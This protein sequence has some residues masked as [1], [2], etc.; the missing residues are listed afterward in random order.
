[1]RLFSLFKLEL[2][3]LKVFHY[4]Q[5]MNETINCLFFLVLEI[6]KQTQEIM[7]P[8]LNVIVALYSL[9]IQFHSEY[10]L[11]VCFYICT[12][13]WFSLLTKTD[14]PQTNTHIHFRLTIDVIFACITL[15]GVHWWLN[16][17]NEYQCSCKKCMGKFTDLVLMRLFI[18]ES[19]VIYCWLSPAF[20]IRLLLTVICRSYTYAFW[21]LKTDNPK[22]FCRSSYTFSKYKLQCR[23]K[24]DFG[25]S[26]SSLFS[27][28]RSRMEFVNYPKYVPMKNGQTDVCNE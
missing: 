28:L 20:I 15:C 7:T 17:L 3:Q 1:M 24:P 16:M 9:S 22:A 11:S 27:L 23:L 14:A 5:C 10:I 6:N 13:N 4:S 8:I 19:T 2:S 12:S 26:N 21:A 18:V 25:Q